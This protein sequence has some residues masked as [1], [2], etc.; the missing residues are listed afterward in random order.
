VVL[1]R[2][3]DCQTLFFF[4]PYVRRKLFL[5]SEKLSQVLND[6]NFDLSFVNRFVNRFLR[7]S[8]RLCNLR[9]WL[10]TKERK[11][12]TPES[13]NFFTNGNNFISSGF[14]FNKRFFCLLIKF[15][16]SLNLFDKSCRK[17]ANAD[18]V[19]F[20]LLLWNI[21]IIWFCNRLNNLARADG[22]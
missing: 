4:F 7:L 14:N 12:L 8:H 20:V 19:N 1:F 10:A 21:L 3:I 11:K 13:M 2:V 16:A 6:V 15:T 22:S 9:L 18:W 5:K 17:E